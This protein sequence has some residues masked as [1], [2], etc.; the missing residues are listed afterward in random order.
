MNPHHR[1]TLL[2]LLAVTGLALVV[3][4][5]E[6][7]ALPPGLHHDEALNGLNAQLLLRTGERPIYLGSKFNGDPMLEYSLMVSE[8]LF[9]MT[10]FAVRLPSALFGSLAIPAIFLLA[11]E[12]FRLSVWPTGAGAATQRRATKDAVQPAAE[13]AAGLPAEET[14]AGDASHGASYPHGAPERDIS[15]ARRR[16][17]AA[18]AASFI[19]ATLYWH[20]NAS[21]EGYKPIFLPLF[22]ALGFWLLLRSFAPAGR[23]PSPV[24]KSAE[25]TALDAAA[26][27]SRS[28]GGH[29]AGERAASSRNTSPR[30]LLLTQVAAG[31]V[32]GLAFYTYPSIRF[33]Y[34]VVALFTLFVIA[35]DRLNAPTIFRRTLLI[36][37]VSLLVFA[38]LGIYFVQHPAAFFTRSDQ[39]SVWVTRPGHVVEAIA[40][41]TLK[42][43]GMFFVAG[44]SNPRQNLPGRPAFDA[45]LAAGFLVGLGVALWRWKQ[46]VYFLLLAWLFAMVLPS[47]LTEAA[48][49]FLRALGATVPAVL[50]VVV[51][52]DFIIVNG[53]ERAA[54]R[55]SA[56][57][58]DPRLWLAGYAAVLL[59][60]AEL[61][62]NAYFGQLPRDP[63]AWFAF[64]VGLVQIAQIVRGLPAGEPVYLTPISTE[65]ATIQFVLGAPRPDFK[66]FDGRRCVVMPPASQPATML[67]VSEDF[68]SVDL[69]QSTWPGGRISRQINDFA[70]KNYLTVYEVPA[71][72]AT[73]VPHSQLSA[74]FGGQAVLM[75]YTLLA[76]RVESG[77]G[78]PLV[79]FWRAQQPMQKDYTVFTHLLGGDNSRTHTLL[80]G[81]R[82][83]MP[84]SAGYPTSRWGMG[85]I[86]A[87]D[88]LIVVDKDAPP[89]PYQIE[90]GLYQLESGARLALPN[91]DDHVLLG[92]VEI[93]RK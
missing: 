81:Q 56:I 44:D 1:R 30:V 8:S 66:S 10:P 53:L 45:M 2:L 50:L 60:S 80:W 5:V 23:A 62:L 46:P 85:E 34:P 49:N 28:E 69:L 84:C 58:A 47:I 48:P 71:Q 4:L 82:D 36:A 68:R 54:G 78:V 14:R 3:R 76:E 21:R 64:D 92:P 42:V 29:A 61:S 52:Y 86:V 77:Q 79:L 11:Q 31:V 91:G 38:P 35:R 39:V 55:V 32:L 15:D 37:V 7:D 90:V 72:P 83:S 18:V 13:P 88:F 73:L 43:A 25:G 27:P 87:E 22:G 16:E 17:V 24:V 65:Q 33:L 51:G 59:C 67:V 12:M 57:L 93:F 75:G 40:D 9:G 19:L 74:S 6:L 63:S 70:G 26:A 20:I 89:G 41:N